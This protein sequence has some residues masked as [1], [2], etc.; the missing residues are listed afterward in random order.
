[1]TGENFPFV[2]C[3]PGEFFARDIEH[4]G[5]FVSI[6]GIGGKQ[7]RLAVRRKIVHSEYLLSFMRSK[8]SDLPR[9]DFRYKKYLS[10][11]LWPAPAYKQSTCRH[12]T[13][14]AEGTNSNI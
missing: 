4:A 3:Q 13:R 8:Q 9:R 1:M 6:D 5:V 14:W 11:S 2:F 12:A 10:W 7:Q